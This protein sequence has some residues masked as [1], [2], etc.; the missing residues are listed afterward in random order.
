MWRPTNDI[1]PR[2]QPVTPA[3]APHMVQC[4][5]EKNSGLDILDCVLAHAHFRCF[6]VDVREEVAVGVGA[7]GTK[8]VENFGERGRGHGDLAEVV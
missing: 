8:F 1:L 5:Q 4:L 6:G 2:K 7:V 3:K